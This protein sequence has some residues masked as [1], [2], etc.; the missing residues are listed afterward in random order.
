MQHGA[1]S[2]I[3]RL[4]AAA[5]ACA[6]VLAMSAGADARG[7][8]HRHWQR[9]WHGGVFLALPPLAIAPF[10]YGGHPYRYGYEYGPGAAYS[11]PAASEGCYAGAYVCP[12][13]GPAAVGMPCSCETGNGRAWG[14][15]R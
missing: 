13:E 7:P 4:T 1:M 9:G 5:L 15:A 3:R 8:H 10:A 2:R 14:A 6:A 12:L 11:A